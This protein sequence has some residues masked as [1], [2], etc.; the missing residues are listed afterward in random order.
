MIGSVP[1]SRRAIAFAQALDEQERDEGAAA[2]DAPPGPPGDNKAPPGPPPP[3]RHS[4]DSV[5]SPDRSLLALAD[6]LEALP[7]PELDP[8]VKVVQRAQLIAA[9]EAAFAE[10]ETAAEGA[11]FPEQRDARTGSRGSGRGAHRAPGLG[12]LGKL[13]PK[14]RLGKGLAAGGLSVGVAASALGGAAAASTDALPGDSLYGLKRGME[15]LQLDLAGDDADR[16]SLFLDHAST[17]MQEARRLMERDRAGVLDHESLGEVRRA[18]AGVQHDASEG[19][20]LLSEAYHQDGD[21]GRMQSLSTFSK[22]HR[23]GW[24]HLRDRLPVQLTD[25][26]NEVSSVF[27]AIDSDVSPLRALFPREPEAAPRERGQDTSD[28]T[29]EEQP[30]TEPSPPSSDGMDGRRDGGEEEPAPSDSQHEGEGLL[31]GDLLKPSKEPRHED[32]PSESGSDSSPGKSTS[33]GGKPE[34]TLPPIIPEVLP[35]L[36]LDDG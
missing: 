18:L 20:R 24:A 21:I 25:V 9:M 15:D 5:A 31:G 35:G 12:P 4:A 27:D 19:H 11:H 32:K 17:R 14:S 1:T 7:R 33:P 28:R 2:D 16:G 26:G 34:V 13:R 6:E 29:G 8:E 22:S 30:S 36:G 23:T 3:H 10:G